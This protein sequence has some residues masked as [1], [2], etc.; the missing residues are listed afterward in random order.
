MQK[1][2]EDKG[3]VSKC[4]YRSRL[5]LIE[6]AVGI[7]FCESNYPYYKICS[8]CHNTNTAVMLLFSWGDIHRGT[9]SRTIFFWGGWGWGY[10]MRLNKPTA[11]KTYRNLSKSYFH[12][13]E[14]WTPC[15]PQLKKGSALEFSIHSMKGIT[16]SCVFQGSHILQL[17]NDDRQPFGRLCCYYLDGRFWY[18]L[19]TLYLIVNN[20]GPGIACE[21]VR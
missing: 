17:Y 20:Q 16:F 1:L 12:F 4:K 8:H 15:T 19:N 5:V 7:R 2:S 14:V 13:S 11:I 6:L 3:L 18:P 21:T 9:Q 10:G